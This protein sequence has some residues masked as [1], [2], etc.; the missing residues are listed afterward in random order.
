MTKMDI[1]PILYLVVPCYNEESV[2]RET[3]KR[4]L[5]KFSTLVKLSQI[6]ANSKVLL[7]DDGSSDKT[8]EII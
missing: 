4:L 1:L 2:L 8:W 5:E 3:S 7:V 6:N